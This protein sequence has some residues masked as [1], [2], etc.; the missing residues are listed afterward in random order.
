MINNG[1]GDDSFMDFRATLI[2]LGRTPF[3]AALADADSLADFN[4]DPAWAR[5]EGYQY[6][7]GKV[8]REMS[9]KDVPRSRSHPK[10]T[11]GVR[12]N[13]WEMSPRFPKLV[14]KYGYKD[15]DWLGGKVRRDKRAKD[16]GMADRLATLMLEAG[17]IPSCG[18]IPP[19]RIVARVLRMGRAP[20]STGRQYTWEPYELDEGHY[21][22]A[23]ARLQGI[24]PEELRSRP[25]L[26]GVKLCLDVGTAEVNNF[27]DWTRTL[28]ER[29]L[30]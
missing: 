2:S 6:V 10:K 20:E 29:G 25:D 22:I 17:I 7:A 21:W 12:F 19:P 23:A 8:Y 3:E 27:E 18:L 14:A 30:A 4:I 24:R 11:T 5:Y 26:Q 16:E 9:G 15:A 28:K 1:C 13:E